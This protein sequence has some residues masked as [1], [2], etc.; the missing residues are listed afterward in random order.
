MSGALRGR[1]VSFVAIKENIC[2][3]VAMHP[4]G[5]SRID[6]PSSVLNELGKTGAKC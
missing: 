2:V 5:S 4:R 3:H 6:E 1:G